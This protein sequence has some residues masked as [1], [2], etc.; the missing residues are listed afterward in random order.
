MKTLPSFI[1]VALILSACGAHVNGPIR[2]E[3]GRDAIEPPV[4]VS[5]PQPP[6]GQ[7]DGPYRPGSTVAWENDDGT[8][9]II[10]VNPRSGE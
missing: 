4:T 2:H 5:K 9:G 3:G 10:S 6:R 1:L 8:F 7:P